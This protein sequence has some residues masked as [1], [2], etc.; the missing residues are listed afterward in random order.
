M[1]EAFGMANG[2]DLGELGGRWRGAVVLKRDVFSTIERGQFDTEGGEIAAVLRRIDGVPWWSW[3]IA[4]E[5]FRRERRGLAIAGGL[6][7]APPLYFSGRR[8]LVR[9][10]IDGVSLHLAKP[11][12]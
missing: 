6:G 4:R 10:W 12:G 11:Y 8:F 1:L 2:G 7:I 3:A 9:G 5:L